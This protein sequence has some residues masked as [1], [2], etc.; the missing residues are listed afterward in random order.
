MTAALPERTMM[1]GPTIYDA[2]VDLVKRERKC[3]AAFVQRRLGIGL[4]VAG[5]CLERMQAEGLVSRPDGEGKRKV[6]A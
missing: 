1:P 5:E 3:G 2:A 6:L 4:I